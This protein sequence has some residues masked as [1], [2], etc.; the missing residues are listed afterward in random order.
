MNEPIA[1]PLSS[2]VPHSFKDLVAMKAAEENLEFYPLPGKTHEGRQVG[3]C[4][5]VVKE[6]IYGI[7]VCNKF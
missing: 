7:I 3:D 1:P 5:Q 2:S 4:V 6:M